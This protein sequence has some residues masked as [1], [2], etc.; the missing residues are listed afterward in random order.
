[1]LNENNCHLIVA[2]DETK[3][4]DN[5]ELKGVIEQTIMC[6]EE[7]SI[8][9]G[10][11]LLLAKGLPITA[12]NNY[13]STLNKHTEQDENETSHHPIIIEECCAI[14]QEEY[15][16]TDQLCHSSSTS[17]CNHVFHQE[18]ILHWPLSSGCIKAKEREA[19]QRY[20]C[21]FLNDKKKKKLPQQY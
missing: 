9:C 2:E 17:T 13:P 6:P 15:K 14:C 10:S 4:S 5:V 11:H 16:P 7:G 8:T 18:C 20:H 3:E 12:S 1:M 19:I 21:Y